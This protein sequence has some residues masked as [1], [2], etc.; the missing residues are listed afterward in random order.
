MVRSSWRKSALPFPCLG[1]KRGKMKLTRPF[2]MLAIEEPNFLMAV[3]Q[4]RLIPVVRMR[5][6]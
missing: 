3:R 5:K 1:R 6:A 2:K 4:L